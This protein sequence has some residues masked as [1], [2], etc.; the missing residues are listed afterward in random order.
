MAVPEEISK[1]V[2]AEVIKVE[3]AINVAAVKETLK[4]EIPVSG[5]DLVRDRYTI[6]IG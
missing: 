4:S 3:T 1:Q 6:E 5:A 2:R